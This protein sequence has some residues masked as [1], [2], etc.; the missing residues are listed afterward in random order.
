MKWLSEK[1]L[2]ILEQA[3]Y[4]IS[5]N[6]TLRATAKHFNVSKSTVHRN[7]RARLKNIDLC[8]FKNAE[9]I[10]GKNKIERTERGGEA[11]R[12]KYLK[13]KEGNNCG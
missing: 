7:L 5:N 6:S 2:K 12:M 11:T 10:L 3:E 8:L 9:Q 4:F 1:E 13:Q